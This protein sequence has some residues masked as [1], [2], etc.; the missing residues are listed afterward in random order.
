M[1]R[2]IQ[3]DEIPELIRLCKAHAAYEECEYIENG[4]LEKLQKDLFSERPLLYCYVVL[5]QG[6]LSGYVTFMKQ[7]ATWDAEEYVYLDCL[8]LD[9]HARN[10]GLGK[11]LMLEVQ[12]AAEAM[13]CKLV[14]WQTPDFNKNAIEFYHHLGATAKTKERFFW[15]K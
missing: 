9:E 15:S 2:P 14:Q 7:Y 3:K 10:K 6:Q 13:G 1:I 4:Q 11:A 12:S 5:P 8:Y